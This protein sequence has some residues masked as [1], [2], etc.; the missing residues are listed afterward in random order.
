MR[1]AL[2]DTRFMLQLALVVF[3]GQGLMLL[4]H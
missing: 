2:E 3:V 1:Q 4:V